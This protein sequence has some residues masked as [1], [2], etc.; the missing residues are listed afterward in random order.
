VK[1]GGQGQVNLIGNVSYDIGG[2]TIPP[3]TS[4]TPPLV[5][6]DIVDIVDGDPEPSVQ[7]IEIE[8]NDDYLNQLGS[9][10]T[11][12]DDIKYRL[13]SDLGD[14]RTGIIENG[15]IIEIGVRLL[16]NIVFNFSE[17]IDIQPLDKKKVAVKK[18]AA[19]MPP[20]SAPAGAGGATKAAVAGTTKKPPE[21]K[22]VITFA[23]NVDKSTVSEYSLG[24]IKD[25]MKKADVEELQ[26][27]STLRTEADQARIMYNNIVRFGVKHQLRLYGATADR[28]I[29]RY[30]TSLAAGKSETEIK[31]DM[32][33]T[34]FEIKKTQPLAFTHTTDPKL[35]NTI[36]IR[37]KSIV[38]SKREDFIAAAKSETRLR[39]KRLF[40]PPKD[41]AI[42]IEILQPKTK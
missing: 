36:D 28:V 7:D 14:E 31:A 25:M 13:R 30:A 18:A 4:V 27:N 1:L 6:Q 23:S 21:P 17:A 42:H 12:T 10:L 39:S 33:N 22:Q 19:K 26:I 3:A 41:P 38:N 11:L 29:N 16:Q 2:G 9:H 40:Y 15:K 34:I 37:Y 5:V 24:I 35:L 32:T 20:A 8:I